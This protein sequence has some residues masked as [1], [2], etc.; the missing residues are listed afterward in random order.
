MLRSLPMMLTNIFCVSWCSSICLSPSVVSLLILVSRSEAGIARCSPPARLPQPRSPA[1]A[2]PTAS[3]LAR[4]P[5]QNQPVPRRG[6][7]HP[8][9]GRFGQAALGMAAGLSDP[10][11]LMLHVQVLLTTTSGNHF[12]DLTYITLNITKHQT[13]WLRKVPSVG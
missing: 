5:R 11:P 8:W 2:V 6:S 10:S 12:I 4:S 9:S 1:Q 13:L 7:A 3:L